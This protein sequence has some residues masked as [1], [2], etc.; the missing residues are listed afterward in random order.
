MLHLKPQEALIVYKVPVDNSLV[1]PFVPAISPWPDNACLI[2][3]KKGSASC[4]PTKRGTSFSDRMA[5]SIV[6]VFVGFAER[7]DSSHLA[8][9]TSSTRSVA[10]PS[11][12]PGCGLALE[13][14]NAPGTDPLSSAADFSNVRDF[15]GEWTSRTGQWERAGA[16]GSGMKL[17][18]RAR[19]RLDLR[20]GSTTPS[21]STVARRSWN[22]KVASC[23]PLV[24]SSHFPGRGV[25]TA[26]G[27]PPGA[28][29][30]GWIDG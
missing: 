16:S 23:A 6:V 10:G 13:T 7:V 18:Y 24:R 12:T 2:M 26:E 28:Y 29:L 5:R 3:F 14:C 30:I 17:T 19:A 20:T 11:P 21:A 9:G 25:S 4:I 27:R 22:S 8:T 15:D 1:K